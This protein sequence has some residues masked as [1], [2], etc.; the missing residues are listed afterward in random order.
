MVLLSVDALRADHVSAYGYAAADD[1]ERRRARARGHRFDAAY[2]PTPHTSYSL[3]SMMTGKYLRP[4]LALGLGRTRRRGRSISAATAGAR[5]RSIRRRSS[6]STRIDSRDSRTSISGSSTR[7]S[8][9]PIRRCASNRWR[10]TSTARRPIG[11]SSSGCTSSSRTSRT[12]SHPE[13]LFRAAR[14]PTSTP[15]T[16]RSR[17]R[18]TASGDRAP[19]RARRPGAVIIVTADHGEEFGEHGGR[20]HGTTVY[21][22]QVRVPLV[23]VGPGRRAG[24]AWRRSCRRSISCRRCSRR[25]AF[26]V[27]RACEGETSGPLLRGDGEGGD[28]PGSRSRRRTIRAPGARRCPARLRRRAA[29]CALYRPEGR[30][31]RA[32][33]RRSERPGARST[34]CGRCFAATTAITD[35]TKRGEDPRGPRRCARMQGDVDA[36]PDVAALLEDA[37]VGIRRKAA[38]VCFDLHAPAAARGEARARARRGRGGARWAALALVRAGSA[39]RALAEALLPRPEPRVAAARGAGTRRARRSAGMRYGLAAWLGTTS[40]RARRQRRRATAARARSRA[41]RGAPSMRRRGARCR[42]RSHRSCVRSTTCARA[43][44]SPTRSGRIGDDRARGPL[45]ELSRTNRTSRP[46]RTRR[47]RF[48]TLG[49]ADCS[50]SPT[51]TARVAVASGP[52]TRRLLVSAVGRRRVARGEG[53]QRALAPSTDEGAGPGVGISTL[54]PPKGS[55]RAVS[56]WPP[57]PASSSRIW[58]LPTRDPSWRNPVYFVRDRASARRPRGGVLCYRSARPT[59]PNSNREDERHRVSSPT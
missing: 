24:G 44:T 21:E 54:C 41:C 16:A 11:R 7:R 12:S 28:D 56:T 9:S 52:R 14:R 32:T 25:W 10:R 42:A 36:A 26:R 57:R 1:A 59:T 53:Q 5:R 13:H 3:T 51:S 15:T 46:G 35:D 31:A 49:A 23:V 34:R 43:P 40:L 38:E 39:R 17:R 2:C 50:P 55:R 27:R 19:G 18:T 4:L 47:A 6:S 58:L 8:S 37:N 22:E 29:A 33:R 20:Y 48:L 45:L 30:P